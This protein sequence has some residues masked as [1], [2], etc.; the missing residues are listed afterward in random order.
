MGIIQKATLYDL[1][2]RKLGPTQWRN[3]EGTRIFSD[4]MQKIGLSDIMKADVERWIRDKARQK[5]V[6]Q[7]TLL[8]Y[9]TTFDQYNYTE[10]S[11]YE[12]V[13][14][15]VST[16][17]AARQ[18]RVVANPETLIPITPDITGQQERWKAAHAL[19]LATSLSDPAEFYKLLRYH[20][21]PNFFKAYPSGRVVA[22]IINYEFE[23]R[24]AIVRGGY[25][26]SL[27]NYTDLDPDRG[28]EALNNW[29]TIDTFTQPRTLG[30]LLGFAFY[31]YI[32]V[33]STGP[34]GLRL[35]FLFDPPEKYEPTFPSSWL[36][37]AQSH[38]NFGDEHR[39]HL[40]VLAGKDTTIRDH[41]VHKRFQH[42]VC[43]SSVDIERFLKWAIDR[44]NDLTIHLA[45]PC[46]FLDK[47]RCIDF[48]T[49]YEYE[50]SVDRILRK[51]IS[52]IVSEETAVRKAAS[53]E[54]A[55]LLET[56]RCIWEPS[57]GGSN[58]YKKLFHPIE[59]RALVKRCLVS[60][61]QPFHSYFDVT[62]DA[63]YDDLAKTIRESVWVTTKATK[64]G[65]LVK[66]K[67][68][69]SEVEENTADFTA[70]VFRALRNAHHGYLTRADPDKY[71]PS[72]YLALVNGN[73]PDSLAYLG[74]LWALAM[75]ASP[76]EMLSWDWVPFG[77][78]P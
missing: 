15:W 13:R 32:H 69:T 57:S 10:E 1:G 31:P 27:N 21:F 37:I 71:R 12:F 51:A 40:A 3:E 29:Q 38:W 64:N 54:I 61:P 75:I 44:Y 58:F 42:S 53:M 9:A 23:N 35:F 2:F 67:D 17:Y 78:G 36:S 26:T 4:V 59:G 48:V 73:T 11:L 18:K 74:Y 68:L 76:K 39:D 25:A 20:V 30:S 43:F 65:F 60:L 33:F 63:L 72:R 66:K 7:P 34:F 41:A 22:Y 8:N 77:K 16:P 5:G 56:L 49:T 6:A 50:L 24:Y 62:V 47:N 70:N 14:R 45:D 19:S 52:C 28:F 46:E 55:D